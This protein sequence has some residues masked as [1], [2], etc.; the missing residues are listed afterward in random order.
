MLMRQLAVTELHDCNNRHLDFGPV[1]G[2]PGSIN[3]DAFA[4]FGQT[5]VHG[6]DIAPNR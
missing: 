2:T 4:D 5:L 6:V 1:G 3:A